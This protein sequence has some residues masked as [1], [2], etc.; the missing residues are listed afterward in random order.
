MYSNLG[1]DKN[2]SDSRESMKLME[3][4]KKLEEAGKKRKEDLEKRLLNPKGD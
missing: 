2:H 3:E 4:M 1:K